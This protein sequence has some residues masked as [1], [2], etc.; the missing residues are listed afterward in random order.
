M[1]YSNATDI[2][3]TCR[4][5]G[6]LT[7]LCHWTR[8]LTFRVDADHKK[9]LEI[10]WEIESA[11]VPAIWVSPRGP[12]RSPRQCRILVPCVRCLEQVSQG[13]PMALAALAVE[14][15]LA[16]SLHHA[17]NFAISPHQ[18][19]DGRSIRKPFENRFQHAVIYR[20]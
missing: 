3:I 19:G 14:S 20:V 10:S 11:G 18:R 6:G 7:D 9:T 8:S 1:R 12:G 16:P 4:S 17:E 13:L 15:A 5:S 2:E